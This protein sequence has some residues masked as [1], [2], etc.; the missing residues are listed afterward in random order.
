MIS[1]CKQNIDLQR[2]VSLF[3]WVKLVSFTIFMCSYILLFSEH[4]EGDG[5]LELDLFLDQLHAPGAPSGPFPKDGAFLALHRKVDD[6]GW[7]INP[8]MILGKYPADG[9]DHIV[10][11]A[12]RIRVLCMV[13]ITHPPLDALSLEE[14]PGTT[15]HQLKLLPVR[16]N[17][18]R[19]TELFRNV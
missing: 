16:T 3:K 8:K 19:T 14:P 4:E 17:P 13:I 12:I 11:V 15:N 7:A 9:L 5:Q 1:K 6:N 18:G 10:V 2:A